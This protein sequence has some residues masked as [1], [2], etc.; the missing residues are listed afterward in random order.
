[1]PPAQITVVYPMSELRG[2][3]VS[4]LRSWTR[5]QTLAR[6]RYRVIAAFHAADHAHAA[7]IESLLGPHD[8]KLPV[9]EGTAGGF[10]R[11]GSRAQERRGWC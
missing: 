1:M 4:P 8:E 7:T 5:D 10:S 3:D 11:L 2:D 6:D 9:P